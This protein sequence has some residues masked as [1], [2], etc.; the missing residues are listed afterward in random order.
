MDINNCKSTRGGG[1]GMYIG[2]IKELNISSCKF[3]DNVASGELGGGGGILFECDNLG[4]NYPCL[5]QITNNQ[6]TSNMADIEGG[7]IMTTIAS[8][9]NLSSNIFLDNQSLYRTNMAKTLTTVQTNYQLN[10]GNGGEY[11]GEIDVH[12]VSGQLMLIPISIL[13]KDEDGNLITSDSEST[14]YVHDIL[15]QKVTLVDNLITAVNGVMLFDKLK[16]THIPNSSISNIYIY[17][18]IL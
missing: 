14:L 3:F 18:Y 7:A 11:L 16:V 2:N 1:G 13:L 8:L 4:G 6:F 10:G 12:L 5:A 9:P 15:N 17:I